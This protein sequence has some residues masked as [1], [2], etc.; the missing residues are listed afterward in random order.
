MDA[1]ILQPF[2]LDHLRAPA[3]IIIV[4]TAAMHTRLPRWVKRFTSAMSELCPLFTRSRPNRGRL[5]TSVLGQQETSAP[6]QIAPSFD[7]L[8]CA[9]EH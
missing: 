8:V 3:K 9:D 4:S 2:A 5:V 1:R 7:Y 6:Q